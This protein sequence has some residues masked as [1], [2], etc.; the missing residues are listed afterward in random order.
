[1]WKGNNSWKTWSSP[2][3]W[4]VT[5]WPLVVHNWYRQLNHFLIGVCCQVQLALT[6]TP[7]P[8][9][10]EALALGWTPGAS[11]VHS[12]LLL[13]CWFTVPGGCTLIH[14]PSQFAHKAPQK[15]SS[16]N[17]F[18]LWFPEESLKKNKPPCSLHLFQLTCSGPVGL[19]WSQWLRKN[20][21]AVVS[22]DVPFPPTSPAGI[23]QGGVRRG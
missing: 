18:A 12:A 13:A 9:L 1:M 22:L 14:F 19:L 2:K 11:R 7:A 5:R 4:P 6:L 23:K 10:T 17:I 21:W 8:A 3:Y 16:S 20:Q 15:P